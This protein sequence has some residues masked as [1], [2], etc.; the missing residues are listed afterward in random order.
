MRRIKFTSSC[1]S[2]LSDRHTG[3]VWFHR[4]HDGR[5]WIGSELRPQTYAIIEYENGELDT[6]PHDWIKFAEPYKEPQPT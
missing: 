2:C 5:A 6:V 1:P 4:W 3:D